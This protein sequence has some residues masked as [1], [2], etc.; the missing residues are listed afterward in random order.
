MENKMVWSVTE[1]WECLK[2]WFE[3]KMALVITEP[4]EDLRKTW[5]ENKMATFVTEPRECLKKT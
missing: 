5:L 4:T 1:T 2:E 3:N